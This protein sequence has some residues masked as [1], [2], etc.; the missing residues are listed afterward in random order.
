MTFSIAARCAQ[1]GM[2]G[3]AITTSSIAVGSRC[4]FGRAG[5]GFAFAQNYADPRLSRRMVALLTDGLDSRKALARVVSEGSHMEH[6]QLLLVDCDGNTAHF[7]GRRGLRIHSA[8]E[9]KDCVAAGNILA[10]TGVPRAMVDKFEAL[11][12]ADLPQRLLDSLAAGLAAGGEA[13][14][15]RAANLVVFDQEEW[16]FADLRVDWHVNPIEELQ[17]VWAVYK[18]Q[19]PDFLFRALDPDRAPYE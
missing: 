15:V 8:A 2:L 16:P 13:C 11:A 12:G 18:P 4:P 1:T 10:N 7:T 19:M 6:R 3:G 9:G 5:V 14:P 17:K